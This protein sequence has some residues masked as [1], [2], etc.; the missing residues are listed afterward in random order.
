MTFFLDNNLSPLLAAG[1]RAFGEDAQHL[2][3]VFPADTADEVWL[4][5]IGRRGW[6]LVSRDKKIAKKR[7][8][9]VVLTEAG[10]G[11]FFFVQKKDYT[12]WEWVEVVVG[13]WREMKAWCEAHPAPFVAGI[14]ERGRIHT[15]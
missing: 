15:L 10:V 7:A 5:D 3:D 6:Y 1:L 4:P 9:R 2:R 11:A 8:Q 13:R 12:G 14:P